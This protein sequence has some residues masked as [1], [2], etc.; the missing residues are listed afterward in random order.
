MYRCLF[1]GRFGKWGVLLFTCS[2]V[3]LRSRAGFNRN[4]LGFS[5][6]SDQ[7]L[8]ITFE[9]INYSAELRHITHSESSTLL[10]SLWKEALRPAAPRGGRVGGTQSW[11]RRPALDSSCLWS[12]LLEQNLV[13]TAGGLPAASPCPAP[14]ELRD[15]WRWKARRL[16]VLLFRFCPCVWPGII[17][18]AN[19]SICSRDNGF[20]SWRVL[21]NMINHLNHC[22]RHMWKRKCWEPEGS[23]AR[24]LGQPGQGGVP[25]SHVDP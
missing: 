22:D 7:P 8:L 17:L 11:L 18:A 6:C 10:P 2:F 4:S 12:Q 25:A 3:R 16:R 23:W 1:L 9:C 20:P 15:V 21:G 5:G 14:C 19:I 24:P 13:L